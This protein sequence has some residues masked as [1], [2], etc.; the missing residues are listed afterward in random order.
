MKKLHKEEVQTAFRM[1]DKVQVDW[2][3]MPVV[4]E[5]KAHGM[6]TLDM[7]PKFMGL[8]KSYKEARRQHQP[9]HLAVYRIDTSSGR[10]VQEY[11]NP[12]YK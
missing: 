12:E 3:K 9:E 7:N 10:K 5:L 6:V 11:I 2:S 1:H 4:Y 8:M